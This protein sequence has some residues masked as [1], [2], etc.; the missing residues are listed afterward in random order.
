MATLAIILWY[1]ESGN[2]QNQPTNLLQHLAKQTR[3]RRHAH[4]GLQAMPDMLMRGFE[5]TLLGL[6]QIAARDCAADRPEG[7][8]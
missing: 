8:P 6:N 2:P 1:L 7:A 5:K 3:S 4:Q